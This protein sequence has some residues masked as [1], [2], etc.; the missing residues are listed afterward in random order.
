MT[1]RLR[2]V[3]AVLGAMTA[4]TTGAVA[5]TTATPTSAQAA[6]VHWTPCH[7]GLFCARYEVPLD[8]DKPRGPQISIALVK[9]PARDPAHR[10]GS[11]FV[12]PGGPGG[13]GVDFVVQE[14]SALF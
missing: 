9:Q 3:V 10:I 1:G 6:P 7:R 14:G 2:R 11:L 13:S 12:N 8:Y 5:V 4:A